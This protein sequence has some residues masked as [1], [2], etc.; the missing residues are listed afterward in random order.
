MKASIAEWG[1]RWVARSLLLIS[2]CTLTAVGSAAQPAV[3]LNDLGRVG[4][5]QTPTARGLGAGTM[6]FGLSR[7]DPIDAYY[8]HVQPFDW[9]QGG[10]RFVN[11]VNPFLSTDPSRSDFTDKG[12]DIQLRLLRESRFIPRVGLG[13]LDLGGNGLLASEYIVGSKRILDFDLHFGLGWG[14]L[15]KRGDANGIFQSISSRFDERRFDFTRPA[16]QFAY[17]SWFSGPVAMFGGLTWTP[18]GGDLSLILE[19]EGNDYQQERFARNPLVP[20][21]APPDVAFPADPEVSSRVNYGLRYRFGDWADLTVSWQRGEQLGVNF[22]TH[23]NFDAARGPEKVQQPDAD[24]LPAYSTQQKSGRSRPLTAARV[25]R[26]RRDLKAKWMTVHAIDAS[27][28]SAPRRVTI[29]VSQSVSTSVPLFAAH[30]ARSV[31]RHTGSRF[32]EITVVELVGGLESVRVTI[33]R[34]AFHRTAM[35]NWT[36]EELAARVR[37]EQ[38]STDR[39]RTADFRGLTAYPAFDERVSP[40]LRSNIG[41]PEEFALVELQARLSGS[42]QLTPQLSSSGTVALR[43]LDNYGDRIERDFDSNL[44]KVRSDSRRYLR[45]GSD[46]YLVQLEANYLF[47]VSSNI[48][49]RVSGGIFEEMF[50][51]VAGEVLYRRP[52]ARWAIGLE[53]NHV[54]QRDFDQR[55]SF[56]SYNV[57]TGHLTYYHE[58]P[59]GGTRLKLSIGR[60]LAKDIGTTID[61][62]KRFDSGARFGVFATFTNVSSETFGEGSFD[63]GFY[64]SF[65]FSLFSAYEGKGKSSFIFRP[66]Q[67]DGGQKVIAGR[68]LYTAFDRTHARTV[69]SRFEDWIR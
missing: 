53:A 58:L 18:G 31:I 63:K 41:S 50:G 39:G 47:P 22:A 69:H 20:E 61:L 44:P 32:S 3:S 26:I 57:T 19:V 10:F 60:Y 15:G 35:G 37:L 12:I 2:A 46:A 13:L 59:Y 49:G 36:P 8:V 43:L 5:L 52:E 9:L 55:F 30:V 38:L 27:E 1:R 16:G 48:I 68:S 25:E 64:V 7:T 28:G 33:P 4:L 6:A 51:G 42:V 29:W 23:G 45:Q 40:S 17:D 24:A 14:R 56:Q 67:R 54:W 66:I 62:S 34:E 21:S 65:P 11:I